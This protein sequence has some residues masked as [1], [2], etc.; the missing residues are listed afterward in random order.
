[1]TDVVSDLILGTPKQ[2]GV[3]QFNV[4]NLRPAG[5]STGFQQPKSYQEGIA[6]LDKQLEIY[7]T[8]H[9]IKTIRD[10][11][12]RYAPPSE[13]DTNAYI[14]YLSNKTGLKPDQEIDLKNPVVRHVKIGRAHV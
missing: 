14:Q 7:G 2:D 10:L 3:N 13:N 12:T 11:V 6:A 5:Q 1:M 9:N 8:K 4:G